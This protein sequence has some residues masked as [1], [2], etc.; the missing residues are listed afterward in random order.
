MRAARECMELA[1]QRQLRQNHLRAWVSGSIIMPAIARNHGAG[2]VASEAE[3]LA[4]LETLYNSHNPTRRW[5]HCTR[6][7]W[8][9]AQIRQCA[10]KQGRRALEV[11]FGAGVYLAALAEAYGEVVASDLD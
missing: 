4:L 8:I 11:G 6:R 3:L 5:L 10:H 2:A 1:S 9:I 7:D